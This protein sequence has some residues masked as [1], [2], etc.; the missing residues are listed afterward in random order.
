[1]LIEFYSTTFQGVINIL[2]F[3][4]YKICIMCTIATDTKVIF[5]NKMLIFTGAFY[6]INVFFQHVY[7]EYE[8]AWRLGENDSIH[9]EFLFVEQMCSFLQNQ[10]LTKGSLDRKSVV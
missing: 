5:F 8:Q 10:S 3:M 9:Y 7:I 1:M 2:K 6:M 4:L